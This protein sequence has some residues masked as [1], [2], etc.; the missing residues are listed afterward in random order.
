MTRDI[1]DSRD[2]MKCRESQ[3][4]KQFFPLLNEM[5]EIDMAVLMS[6][7]TILLQALSYSATDF[8]DMNDI[9]RIYMHIKH[10]FGGIDLSKRQEQPPK[11]SIL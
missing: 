3:N 10:N 8:H 4:C 6:A 9:S 7:S 11:D 1:S 5:E 2:S